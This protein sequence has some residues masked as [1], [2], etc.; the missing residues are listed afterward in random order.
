MAE[1]TYAGSSPLEEVKSFTAGDSYD[2][3]TVDLK[4]SA[5][6]APARGFHANVAGT[7]KFNDGAGNAT[8]K[9][10]NAGTYYPYR[11]TRLWVTGHATLTTASIGLAR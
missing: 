3:D 1:N 8:T 11:V 7:V 6:G 9:V 10:V 4:D 2:S 5:L